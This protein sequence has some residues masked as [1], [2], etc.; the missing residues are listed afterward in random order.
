[1]PIFDHDVRSITDDD[2]RK[3]V[4]RKHDSGKGA[5]GSLIRACASSMFAFA[6]DRKWV[7]ENPVYKMKQLYKPRKRGRDRVLTG[8]EL[9]AI[10][11]VA[12]KC[13]G[14]MARALRLLMMVSCR[15]SEASDAVWKI[16]SDRGEM[17]D[18]TSDRMKGGET[19]VIPLTSHMLAD[20]VLRPGLRTGQCVFSSGVRGDIAVAG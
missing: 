9:G 16:R 7:S 6:V 1:M 14:P 17:D 13:E 18:Y 11:R 15:R 20:D 4:S 5:M 3:I 12:D 2:I 10:L 8:D 19:A